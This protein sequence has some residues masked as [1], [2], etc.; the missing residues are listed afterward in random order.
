[1]DEKQFP[2]TIYEDEENNENLPRPLNKNDTPNR[3]GKIRQI[4]L[5]QR[6]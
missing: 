6:M 2:P 3:F 5:N 1:M 4:T